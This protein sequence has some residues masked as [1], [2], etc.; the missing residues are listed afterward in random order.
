MWLHPLLVIHEAISRTMALSPRA[1]A[2]VVAAM[3]EA[4]LLIMAYR[5]GSYSH[6]DSEITS[7]NELGGVTNYHNLYR[8]LKTVVARAGVTDIGLHGLRHTHASILILRGVNARVV[9][10]RLGHKDVAF[11]LRTY[12]HLFEEQRREAAM[13]MP[14]FLGI[15]PVEETPLTRTTPR[16]LN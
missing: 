8:V 6:F 1:A 5:L 4:F 13:D 12:A 11:T 16:V 9:S 2:S 10:E 3:A 15:A 14:T 7:S